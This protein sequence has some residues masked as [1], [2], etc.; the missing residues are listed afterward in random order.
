[1]GRTADLNCF[2]FLLSNWKKQGSSWYVYKA[3]C[4]LKLHT[5]KHLWLYEVRYAKMKIKQWM[6][7]LLKSVR[8]HIGTGLSPLFVYYTWRRIFFALLWWRLDPYRTVF[9]EFSF[10]TYRRSSATHEK[11]FYSKCVY[12]FKRKIFYRKSAV[13]RNMCEKKFVSRTFVKI[14][15]FVKKDHLFHP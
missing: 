3:S 15:I 12:F 6:Q 1:M 8:C 5:W 9:A 2:T 13:S 14:K 10:L 7:Y 4:L 11:V